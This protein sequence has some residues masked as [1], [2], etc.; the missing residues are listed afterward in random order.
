MCRWVAYIGE[1][2][3]IADLV[4]APE[5]SLIAQARQAEECKTTIN[6]DGFGLAWYN[7]HTQPGLY[8]DVYPA[9]SDMNLRA[10]AEQVS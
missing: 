9:W 2:I 10:L 7:Y 1:P 5:H 3:F 4:S 6:A 8:R